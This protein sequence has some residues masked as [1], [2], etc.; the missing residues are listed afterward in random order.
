MGLKMAVRQQQGNWGG[1]GG[2]LLRQDKRISLQ[3]Y[4]RYGYHKIIIR[5]HFT[6]DNGIIT[7]Y[8]PQIIFIFH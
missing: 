6:N 1:G 5:A 8:L 2:V 4:V 3:G 7:L